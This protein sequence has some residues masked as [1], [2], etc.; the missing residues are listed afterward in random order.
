MVAG[1]GQAAPVP[2]QNEASSAVEVFEQA[3][4][5]HWSVVW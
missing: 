3:A 2:A 1:A 4:A 5:L